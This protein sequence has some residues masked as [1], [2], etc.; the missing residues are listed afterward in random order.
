MIGHGNYTVHPGDTLSGIAA[1]A[2]LSGG[3]E[4]LYQDN[5]ATVGGNPNLIFPGQQ[6]QVA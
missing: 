4:A 3:W 5:K 6:L 1:A 2:H